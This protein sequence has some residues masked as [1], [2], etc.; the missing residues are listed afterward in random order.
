LGLPD[1]RLQSAVPVPQI[2]QR[3]ANGRSGA[4]LQD[5]GSGEEDE[6]GAEKDG[7]SRKLKV[8]KLKKAISFA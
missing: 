1:R 2:P 6:G 7:K 3:Q 4:F 8:R 5:G